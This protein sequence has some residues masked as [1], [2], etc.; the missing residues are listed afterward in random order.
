MEKVVAIRIN[1]ETNQA[2][3]WRR[4]GNGFELETEDV[5]FRPWLV[6]SYKGD[7]VQT[8]RL[9]G[10][11]PIR[12]FHQYP[13][14]EQFREARKKVPY[15]KAVI[16]EEL[17]SQYLA[18]NPDHKLFQGMAFEDLNRLTFDIEADGLNPKKSM[19]LMIAVSSTTLGEFVVE[20]TEP[21][22]LAELEGI[23]RA[24]DPDTIEGHNILGYDIPFLVERART[25][26]MELLW[27]RDGE[28]IR[29][30]KEWNF[31]VGSFDRPV[32]SWEIVGRH[33]VDGLLV[34][35]RYDA[36]TGGKF[37][38]FGLKYL[39]QEM[40][41][42]GEDR[43][44]IAPDNIVQLWNESPE[45]VKEYS[46]QDVRGSRKLIELMV[47]PEFYLT[48][49]LPDTF[50]NVL[51][52]G[53]ATKVNQL[54]VGDYIEAG[55]SIPVPPSESQYTGGHVDLRA[56]GVF[57][58]VAKADVASLYPSI[59]LNSSEARP[60][61]DELGAFQ[62]VLS[63]LTEKRLA[64]K[65]EAKK[66][67]GPRK[68]Y[69]TG[70]E[71]AYKIVINAF[72]G[73]LGTGGMHFADF[74]AAAMVTAIG[75]DIVTQMADQLEGIGMM[76]IEVDTDGVYFQYPEGF[77]TE[78]ISS[79]LYL[80]EWVV[81][82]V[83]EK[84]DAMLSVQAKNYVLKPQGKDKL[85][86]HGNSLRSRRDEHFGR[87]FIRDIIGALLAGQLENIPKM[88][89]VYQG[90]IIAREIDKFDLAKRE[91][92]SDK[93]M[94]SPAKKKLR[95][96]VD[97]TELTE[98]D[99]IQVYQNEVGAY[100]PIEGYASDEDRY[101]YLDRLFKFGKRLENILTTYGIEL[102]KIYKKTFK[103][104]IKSE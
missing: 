71:K 4:R 9:Q 64:I 52:S 1:P 39:E 48:S 74:D 47:Q 75:R 88:Y 85:Q 82:E 80:P 45:I 72:Y 50:Q 98:G 101:Y 78:A 33:I 36:N 62:S 43:V 70:I 93:T 2:R 13:T 69:L 59:M 76:L 84:Y 30:G 17:R 40:G 38:A 16:W 58:N 95:A 20:G 68:T 60:K 10:D 12:W 99:Y 25:H 53:G 81:V 77:P 67:E 15:G 90:K 54:L 5:D 8:R 97:Q 42:A 89:V 57:R 46:L 22:M 92:I 103:E 91:R 35:Q 79:F 61:F 31:R 96:A 11:N 27:G 21:E 6:S 102:K 32:Q 34:A 63:Q 23:I 65:A 55:Y 56:I 26:G 100:V 28:P 87:D 37:E 51:L 7:A 41:V 94:T 66:A 3:L 14:I 19:I 44:V 83:D 49:L 29:K 104:M 86:Y 18:L 73:Y 24:A